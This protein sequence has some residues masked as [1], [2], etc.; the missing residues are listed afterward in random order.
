MSLN[1]IRYS[2]DYIFSFL[3]LSKKIVC[4]G[5]SHTGVFH[6]INYN[7]WFSGYFFKTLAVHGATASGIENPNSK[8]QAKTKFDTFLDS[9]TN[10]NSLVLFQLGEIDCGFVI[11]YRSYKYGETI[12][13]QLNQTLDN[14][15]SYILSAKSKANQI[16]VM[17]AILPTIQDGQDYGEVANLR[18]EVKA[19]LKERTDLTLRFNKLMKKFCYEFNILF[20]DIENQLLDKNTN[21]VKKILLNDNPLDHHLSNQKLGPIIL[22]E[23][24]DLF[25]K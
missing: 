11:W 4:I 20:L 1:R 22:K 7:S 16:I 8:T 24:N 2:I 14:Y 3:K 18:K 9:N 13:E 10:T 12:D 19:S 15:Q 6:F 5:D 23:L 17:S 25:R 21:T